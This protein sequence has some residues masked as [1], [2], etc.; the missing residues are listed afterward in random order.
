[1]KDEGIITNDDSLNDESNGYIPGERQNDNNKNDKNKLSLSDRVIISTKEGGLKIIPE[2]FDDKDGDWKIIKSENPF[3]ILYLDYKQFRT[4]LPKMVNSNFELLKKFWENKVGLMN[5][6]GNRIAYKNKYGDGTVE[7]AI[8]KL[9]LTRNKLANESGIANYYN[10]INNERLRKAEESLK[11]SIEDMLADG[12]ASKQE[13]E[14]RLERG[15]KYDLSEDEIVNIIDKALKNSMFRAFGKISGHTRREQLLSVTWMTDEKLEEQR[16]IDEEKE[17]RGREIFKGSFAYN[18][19]EIGTI[20]FTNDEKTKEYIQK[21]LIIN[22]IDYFSTPKA[23]QILEISKSKNDIDLKYLQIIY[24]LNPK[25]PYKFN[26]KDCSD[27]KELTFAL[28]N[29]HKKGK[30]HFNKG[31]IK[32]WVQEC[33]PENNEI[34]LKIIDSAINLDLAFLEFLYTFNPEL[35]YRFADKLIVKTPDELCTEV[36]KNKENWDFGRNELFDSS[37]ITWLKTI[38]KSIIIEKWDKVKDQ[39]SDRKDDG[40]EYFLQILNDKIEQPALIVDKNIFSYPKVQSGRNISTSFILTN[41]T[42][43]YIEG[44]LSLTKKLDGVSLSPNKFCLNVAAS[45]S[46]QKVDLSIDSMNFRKG[47]TYN[48]EI[49]IITTTK[50]KIIIPVSF[51][52]VFPRNAFIKEIIKYALLFTLFGGLIRSISSFFGFTDWLKAYYPYYLNTSDV[53][54]QKKPEIIYF[55]CIFGCIILFLLLVTLIWKKLVKLLD[56]I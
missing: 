56:K 36:N 52:I 5:T 27:I 50:Q 55:L 53:D 41:K 51:K 22:A 10:E 29:D 8:K 14:I 37:I 40:L 1:M 35:P 43:G 26:L 9:E 4:I 31:Y 19:E 7:N 47:V 32:I 54:W 24:C 20:L 2:G 25:L 42:R 48:T 18:L 13:I 28:F 21:G 6:G 23:A 38:G 34:L 39:Y 16:K 44:N 33:F 30:E 3:E 45:T 15:L 49:Q 12:V 46:N 17:K 11:E